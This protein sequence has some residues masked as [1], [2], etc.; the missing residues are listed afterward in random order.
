[1]LL[2]KMLKIIIWICLKS[3]E[4]INFSMSYYLNNFIKIFSFSKYL[5]GDWKV[6]NSCVKSFKMKIYK[7]RN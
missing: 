6:I 4:V 2:L 5:K 7:F 1:M 3:K